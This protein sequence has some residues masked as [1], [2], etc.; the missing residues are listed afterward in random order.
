MANKIV[1]FGATGFTGRLTAKSLAAQG[2]SPLLVG[3]NQN[4]LDALAKELG[5]LDTAIAN[6]DKLESLASLLNE[7]DVLITTVGPFT[8]YG[9]TAIQAAISK[10]AHYI[11]ST[12]EPGFIRK[13]FEQ[14]GPQAKSAGITLLTAFGY[15]YVPGNAAAAAALNLDD[16]A[17]KVNVGYFVSGKGIS[18]SQGTQASVMQAM[19]DPGVFFEKGRLTE[20]VFDPKIKHFKIAGRTR[21]AASVPGSEHLAL[22][23]SYPSLTDVNTY[24]GWF[25]A[26]SYLM[27]LA[28]GFQALML[29]IPGYHSVLDKFAQKFNRSEG[30]G[31][32][33]YLRSLNNTQVMAVAYNSKGKAVSEATLSGANPYDYTAD[34][35]AWSAIHGLKQGYND[36]GALGPVAAFGSD[37]LFLACEECGLKLSQRKL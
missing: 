8:R 6:A 27:P 9:D 22:P 18:A 15:D 10:K 37:L 11:D 3:R 12:G 25:G 33:E 13:V 36:S 5:G 31:P 26:A 34:M 1:L 20:K 29:K 17:T 14:Y 30:K 21:P 32:N 23:V 2:V 28:T 24:L 7:G 19:L 35:L 4:K 16:S